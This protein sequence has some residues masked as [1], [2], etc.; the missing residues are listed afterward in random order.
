MLNAKN[1]NFHTYITTKYFFLCVCQVSGFSKK[2]HY[3]KKNVCLCVWVFCV[4]MAILSPFIF[5]ITSIKSDT[6]FVPKALFLY[7]SLSLSPEPP[8]YPPPSPPPL[9]V[10]S[11]PAYDPR[12]GTSVPRSGPRGATL[13][14]QQEARQSKSPCV[15][16]P[17]KATEEAA[18][19]T[20]CCGSSF[21]DTPEEEYCC[22]IPLLYDMIT[23]Q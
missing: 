4:S 13:V 19:A 9:P 8:P 3:K 21:Y 10:Q 11:A 12:T 2:I 5:C 17:I 18:Q 20:H 15:R 16:L 7:N 1:N 14:G 23:V 6:Y 22:I